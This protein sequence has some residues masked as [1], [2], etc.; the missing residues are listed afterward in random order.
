G[1]GTRSCFPVHWK[2]SGLWLVV[3]ALSVVL[4]RQRRRT[5]QIEEPGDAGLRRFCQWFGLILF[6]AIALTIAWGCIQEGPMFY[7]TSLFNFAIYYGVLLLFALLSAQWLEERSEE[8][9]SELQSPCNLVCR[10]LLEKK[11]KKKRTQ[12]TLQIK[13][14]KI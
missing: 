14:Y 2:A 5:K 6:A 10:L 4:A 9:T 1:P 13:R 7:Y 12:K 3:L 8:H 11:K